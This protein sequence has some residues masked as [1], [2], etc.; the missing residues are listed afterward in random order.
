MTP[1]DAWVW[2]VNRSDLGTRMRE[3]IQGASKRPA[4]RRLFPCVS[5]ERTLKFSR[6]TEWT[7]S[8]GLPSI[9]WVGQDS[10][11]MGFLIG[12]SGSAP[13]QVADLSAALDTLERCLPGGP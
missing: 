7:F 9:Q 6:T 5:M 12:Q 4:L 3:I 11:P 2:L 8:E 13:V 1:E 10:R